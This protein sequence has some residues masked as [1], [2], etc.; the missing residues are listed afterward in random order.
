MTRID[1]IKKIKKRKKELNI[2]IEN[3]AKISGIGIRTTNRF[4]AGDDVKLSTI[5]K[6]TSL[7]GLDFAG[8]EVVPLKELKMHRAKEKATFMASLVQSTSA[9]EKQGL[10][11]KALD[12]IIHKFEREFLTG[13]Y[14]DRL[15][16][17]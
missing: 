7:L 14:Q 2:T 10:E 11:K 4:F 16:I 5:E 13:Q 15:W 9:L 6:L 12:R 1:L 17:A 3:L 8:N